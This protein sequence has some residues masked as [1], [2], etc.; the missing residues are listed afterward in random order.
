MFFA[1]FVCW[2][3]VMCLQCSKYTL[4]SCVG[5]MWSAVHHSVCCCVWCNQS[6]MFLAR[7]PAVSSTFSL[8]WSAHVCQ[9]TLLHD[10]VV[11]HFITPGVAA[12]AVEPASCA[13]QLVPLMRRFLR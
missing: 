9:I 6:R 5:H 1:L 11:V 2:L 7:K 3:A 8:S 4:V 13:S 10:A 12:A